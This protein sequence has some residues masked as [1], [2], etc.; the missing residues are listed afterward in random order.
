MTLL[1]LGVLL[2]AAS[3]LSKRLM[4]P[5]GVLGSGHRATMA[6]I[7]IVALGLI[8]YGFKAAP[9]I[10]LWYPEAAMRHANNGLMLVALFL[11]GA[12]HTKGAIGARITGPMFWGIL[13][14]A[15]AHLLV[16]GDLAS[17]VLFGGLGLWAVISLGVLYA[18]G[19][20]RAVQKRGLVGDLMALAGAIVLMGA[21]GAVHGWLGYPVF[22]G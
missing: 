20:G 2:W 22:P 13:V 5:D 14:W 17:L 7:N 16:N 11:F 21:I 3:H 18:K 9:V 1:V 4:T 8:I 15:V 10:D 19:Q 6:A 12:G